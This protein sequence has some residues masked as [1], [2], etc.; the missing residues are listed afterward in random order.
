LAFVGLLEQAL[1]KKKYY[2]KKMRQLLHYFTDRNERNK[3]S[4]RKSLPD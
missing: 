1:K 3:F 4:I 2:Q